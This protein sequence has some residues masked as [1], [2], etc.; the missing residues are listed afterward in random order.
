MMQA[1]YFLG[2]TLIPSPKERDVAKKKAK[3]YNQN[4]VNV[5]GSFGCT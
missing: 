3:V 5:I 2:L 1:K 4:N